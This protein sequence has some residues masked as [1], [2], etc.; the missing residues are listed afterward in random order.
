[1]QSEFFFQLTN[2][3][4]EAGTMEGDTT[5]E[6]A[7][8]LFPTKFQRFD[9]KGPYNYIH[10]SRSVIDEVTKCLKAGERWSC[11]TKAK[12]SPPPLAM[13]ATVDTKKLAAL[14][15]ADHCSPRS[16]VVYLPPE[17]EPFIGEM[18]S[19]RPEVCNSPTTDLL[20]NQTYLVLGTSQG[21]GSL[22]I[23]HDEIYRDDGRCAGEDGEDEFFAVILVS[24]NSVSIGGFVCDQDYAD[25]CQCCSM[26][27][28]S[29]VP[30]TDEELAEAAIEKNRVG[31]WPTA[32]QLHYW[33]DAAIDLTTP[34]HSRRSKRGW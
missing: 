32:Y 31:N 27:A 7:G 11:Q 17:L 10:Y 28:Q 3:Q 8:L 18:V 33:R 25:Q 24:G 15:V 30:Y 6:P 2:N 13:G 34:V 26:S 29:Y 19:R 5:A 4:S 1:M 23:I 16:L 20:D 12:W 14:L 22:W 9:P 21:A